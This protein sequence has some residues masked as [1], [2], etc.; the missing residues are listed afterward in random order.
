MEISGF[1][2]TDYYSFIYKP[3]V[4]K[5]FGDCLALLCKRIAHFVLQLF[6]LKLE[7]VSEW[8][9]YESL[10]KDVEKVKEDPRLSC[11]FEQVI[12]SLNSQGKTDTVP[13]S[14]RE[15]AKIA[16][17]KDGL[18][19]SSHIHLYGIQNPD[20]KQ[21]LASI[22]MKQQNYP[23][24]AEQIKNYGFSD[25]SELFKLCLCEIRN[26]G[27]SAELF[28]KY[29]LENLRQDQQTTL[30]ETI[31]RC[32]NQKTVHLIVVI[33]LV[34]KFFSESY[35]VAFAKELVYYHAYV[36]ELKDLSIKSEEDR[37]AIA[38]FWLEKDS[39]KTCQNLP[40]FS[41]WKKTLN[42]FA[43]LCAQKDP[44]SLL[45]NIQDFQFEI[46]EN[47]VNIVKKCV[48]NG[49][50]AKLLIT[51]WFQFA[52]AKR[53]EKYIFEIAKQLA[54]YNA[55]EWLKEIDF[56]KL[57]ELNNRNVMA[58]ICV[59]ECPLETIKKIDEFKLNKKQKVE[60]VKMAVQNDEAAKKMK[61]LIKKINI[62]EEIYRYE[63]VQECI[64][65]LLKTNAKEDVKLII[66]GIDPKFNTL[67]HPNG[68]FI[69]TESYLNE[70]RGM[71]Q[72]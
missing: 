15:A 55:T 65:S 47:L 39:K 27:L 48:N 43:D 66:E 19:F 2:A 50:Q 33:K 35:K 24:T 54:G 7:W 41:L 37:L 56:F 5:S 60:I 16:A 72:V 1:K 4:H 61:N 51:R 42:D 11:L 52:N 26:Y 30:A 44:E 28:K 71:Y 21:K 9:L 13:F 46:D 36:N 14:L 59:K 38:K 53:E 29:P 63:I 23:L 58:K 70:L 8:T 20:E 34:L 62:E 64:K 57:D 68:F 40:S 18:L 25:D 49:T 67:T 69:T 22:A 45:S 32:L 10:S 6:M 17:A 3:D 12:R 31:V